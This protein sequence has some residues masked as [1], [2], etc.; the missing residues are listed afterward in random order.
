M[1]PVLLFEGRQFVRQVVARCLNKKLD[2]RQVFEEGG[3]LSFSFDEV[4]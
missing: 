4:L 1:G 2:D 3:T